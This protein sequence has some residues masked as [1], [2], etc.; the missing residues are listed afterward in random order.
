MKV[1]RLG[2]DDKGLIMQAAFILEGPCILLYAPFTICKGASISKSN[3]ELD[4][5]MYLVRGRYTVGSE[6]VRVER[7]TLT[8][9]DF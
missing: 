8:R 1:L 6:Q 9:N 3:A 2:V 4:S 7:P 5:N